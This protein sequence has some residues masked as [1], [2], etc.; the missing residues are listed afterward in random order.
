MRVCRRDPC[1][2]L[3]RLRTSRAL[4]AHSHLIALLGLK[5]DD[6]YALAATLSRSSR[7]ADKPN[8]ADL[9]HHLSDLAKARITSPLKVSSAL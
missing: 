9:S 8:A 1:P 4:L 2:R 7:A 5:M 6:S 3:S